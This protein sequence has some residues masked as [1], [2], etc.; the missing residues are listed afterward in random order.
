MRRHTRVSIGE[1]R[2]RALRLWPQ[3][4][5][6]PE[7]LGLPPSCCASS[8]R[9]GTSGQERLAHAHLQFFGKEQDRERHCELSNFLE[10]LLA[11]VAVEEDRLQARGDSAALG[12]AVAENPFTRLAANSLGRHAM[13]DGGSA[14]A[15]ERHDERGGGRGSSKE[16][17]KA[18]HDWRMRAL[19]TQGKNR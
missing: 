11:K 19:P 10:A 6:P 13:R 17:A 7:G 15:G 2:E 3:A 18:A 9:E 16:E 1:R 8:T 5:R 12:R 14:R 4:R